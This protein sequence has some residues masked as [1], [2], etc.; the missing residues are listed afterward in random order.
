MVLPA[1]TDVAVQDIFVELRESLRVEQV[2]HKRFVALGGVRLKLTACRS[3]SGSA[4]QMSGQ[5]QVV[6]GHTASFSDWTWR[7]N[8]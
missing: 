8:P 4:H 7:R 3:E 6:I 5:G 2:L 1:S